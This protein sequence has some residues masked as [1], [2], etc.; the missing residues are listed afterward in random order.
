[1]ERGFVWELNLDAERELATAGSYTRSLEQQRFVVAHRD[2]ARAMLG[3]GD[4]ALE[5]VGLQR[6]DLRGRIGRAW[7]PTPGALARLRR[8]GA[9]I[10]EAP[11]LEVL[12]EVN[13]RRFCA[14]LGQTLDGAV[15]SAELD[16]LLA[17]LED[18]AGPANWLAKR[19]LGVA[20]RGR[21]KLGRGTPSVAELSWLRASLRGGGLQL[22]PWLELEAEFDLQGLIEPDGSYQLSKPGLQHIDAHGSW[23]ATHEAL[24][25][26]LLPGERAALMAEG[27]RV[28]E[29]LAER[30]YFGPFGIDSYRYRDDRGR[31]RLQPR[32]E[33]NARYTMGWRLRELEGAR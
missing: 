29:A 21:L 14:E 27:E 23:L 12:R 25:S 9:L 30:G 17:R 15:Y 7:C 22:E 1:V 33:V 19:E 3:A 31:A 28:A 4:V 18:P 16:V 20:G 11:T 26:E 32:S 13:G 2:Q 8:V 10:P 6:E 5:D 24:E